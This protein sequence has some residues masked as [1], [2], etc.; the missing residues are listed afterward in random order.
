MKVGHRV[1]SNVVWSHLSNLLNDE[2]ANIK[3]EIHSVDEAMFL[4]DLKRELAQGKKRIVINV[5][6]DD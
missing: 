5:N 2:L 4:I 1:I 6:Y 3:P